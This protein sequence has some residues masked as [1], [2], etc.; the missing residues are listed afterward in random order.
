M[1]DSSH[2]LLRALN[3]LELSLRRVGRKEYFDRIGQCHFCFAPKGLGVL[4]L[5]K[6]V[7]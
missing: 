6:E 2:H 1:P 4:P 7:C 3:A 5:P